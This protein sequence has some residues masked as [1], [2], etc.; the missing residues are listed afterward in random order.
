[1]MQNLSVLPGGEQTVLEELYGIS[2][3]S[4][5][6]PGARA[7]PVAP[8]ASRRGASPRDGNEQPPWP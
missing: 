2:V 7:Q 4:S 6:L 1:M 8:P 5:S 3:E